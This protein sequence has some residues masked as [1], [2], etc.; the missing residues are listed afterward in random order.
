MP[1]VCIVRSAVKHGSL[2]RG[3]VPWL[4]TMPSGTENKVQYLTEIWLLALNKLNGIHV[5]G[6][7]LSLSNNFQRP[8]WCL[9]WFCTVFLKL[10]IVLI[11]IWWE[12]VP[13]KSWANLSSYSTIFDFDIPVNIFVLSETLFRCDKFFSL[14]SLQ[15]LGIE[16]FLCARSC[17][18]LFAWIILFYFF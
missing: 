7:L 16:C 4:V 13:T 11:R 9:L 5:G 8:I 15:L 12:S 2:T 6:K 14:P 3:Q 18:K 10:N 17:P 1:W